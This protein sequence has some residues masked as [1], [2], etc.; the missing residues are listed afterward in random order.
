MWTYTSESD[1]S[2][3]GD[4]MDD[5]IRMLKEDVESPGSIDNSMKGPIQR[6]S[7]I[8]ENINRDEE[9][10][11]QDAEYYLSEVAEYLRRRYAYIK[12]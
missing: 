4:Y 10:F 9:D 11:K 5:M 8:D 6:Y 3:K 2:K 1:V 7:N 12:E